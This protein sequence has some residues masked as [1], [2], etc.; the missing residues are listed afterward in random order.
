MDDD[1]VGA[2]RVGAVGIWP[3]LGIWADWEGRKLR[4][5]WWHPAKNAVA[6]QALLPA[7]LKALQVLG[8]I[9]VGQSRARLFA[10]VQAGVGTERVVLCLRG[11]VGAVQV[12]GSVA[13]LA[14]ALK[15]RTR[16]ALLRGAQEHRLAGRCDEA[17][18]WSAAARG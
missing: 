4:Q 11:T 7:D 2:D 3:A 17:A 10:G 16:A 6:E 12:R 13:L 5:A 18:A 15:G 14:P 1:R 8:A 9:A